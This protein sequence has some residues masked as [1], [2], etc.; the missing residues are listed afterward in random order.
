MSSLANRQNVNTGLAPKKINK[1]LSLG[2]VVNK[3]FHLS[4]IPTGFP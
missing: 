4:N 2:R 3:T 1:W